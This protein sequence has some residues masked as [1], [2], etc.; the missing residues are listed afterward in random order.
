MFCCSTNP[1]GDDLKFDNIEDLSNRHFLLCLKE[2]KNK[3]KNL[4]KIKY[5]QDVNEFEEQLEELVGFGS[6]K[7]DSK[8]FNNRDSHHSHG[9]YDESFRNSVEK[10]F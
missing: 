4:S 2:L 8:P 10:F 5:Q 1:N 3:V 9:L 6:D 7:K